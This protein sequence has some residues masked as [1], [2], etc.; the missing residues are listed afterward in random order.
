MAENAI[1]KINKFADL[2]FLRY[3]DQVPVF[4]SEV[5]VVAIIVAPLVDWIVPSP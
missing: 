3:A 4:Y 1:I 2:T 5:T